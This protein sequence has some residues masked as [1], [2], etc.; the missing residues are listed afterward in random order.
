M[1][2]NTI[3]KKAKIKVGDQVQVI[4]G[5]DKGNVGKVLRIYKR[6]NRILVSGVNLT[7]RH[8][9]PTQQNES[10]KRQEYESPIHYSNVLV[11]SSADKKGVR[12]KMKQEG[13]EKKRLSAKSSNPI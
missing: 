1:K 12:I 7:M 9:K 5:K 11:Y 13:Q 10:G 6:Q 2:K 4:A 8:L 3:L